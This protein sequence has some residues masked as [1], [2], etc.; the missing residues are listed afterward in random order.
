MEV[1][2]QCSLLR[3]DSAQVFPDFDELRGVVLFSLWWVFQL[4][5]RDTGAFRRAG[6]GG[7]PL[8]KSRGVEPCPWPVHGEAEA[9]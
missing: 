4:E 7:A 1:T 9:P 5:E 2:L 6:G 8:F 3:G